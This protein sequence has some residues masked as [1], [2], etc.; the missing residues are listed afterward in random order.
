MEHLQ[1][2]H[3]E[4][5]HVQEDLDTQVSGNRFVR[6]TGIGV[7]VTARRAPGSRTKPWKTVILMILRKGKN[8]TKKD[9]KQVAR[10]VGE[11]HEGG[12]GEK[13]VANKD[14]EGQEAE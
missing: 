8:S 6:V 12:G 11:E 3:M 5:R 10:E 9:S 2:A 14:R 4:P 1:V 13:R 7:P